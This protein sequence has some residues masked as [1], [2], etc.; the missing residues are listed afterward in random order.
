MIN[1][2]YVVKAIILTLLYVY[3]NKFISSIKYINKNKN[4]QKYNYKIE[5][6]LYNIR[7]LF[8]YNYSIISKNQKYYK[9]LFF[10]ESSSLH[11]N[12]RKKIK[13]SWINLCL[14]TSCN[15]YFVIA[16]KGILDSIKEENENDII[17]VDIVDDYYNLT[18]ITSNIYKYYILNNLYS[19]YI[20]KI[21][22]DI[23]PNIPIIFIYINLYIIRSMISGYYYSRMK[24]KRNKNSSNYLLKSIYP[25]NIFP[26]FVAGGFVITNSKLIHLLYIEL[27]KERRIINRED[28]HMGVIY[29]KLNIKFQKLNYYYHRNQTN[30]TPKIK[31]NDI[32][33]HGY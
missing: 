17:G 29:S 10:I 11:T 21:D 23:F 18:I 20:I 13:K 1:I 26:N 31:L 9:I 3:L 25:H 15:Y 2:N 5:Q 33:W 16:T 4:K 24:V 30:I 12:K 14:K 28:M 8:I 22:D 7:E 19:D 6:S 32:C 27:I